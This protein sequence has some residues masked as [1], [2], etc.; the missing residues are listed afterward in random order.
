MQGREKRNQTVKAVYASMAGC[1]EGAAHHQVND[2]VTTSKESPRHAEDKGK[3]YCE[4]E[5][6][7]GLNGVPIDSRE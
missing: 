6:M 4:I 5:R 7:A 1:R 2:R 3:T